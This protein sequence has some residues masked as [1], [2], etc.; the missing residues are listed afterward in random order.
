MGQEIIATLGKL[1]DFCCCCLSYPAIAP[2]LK[3]HYL[4]RA[5]NIVFTRRVS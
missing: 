5:Q 1:G 4:F 2:L 3:V